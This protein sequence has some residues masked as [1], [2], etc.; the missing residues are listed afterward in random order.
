MIRARGNGYTIVETMIFLVVSGALL[1]SV[2]VLVDGQQRK[3]EFSTVVRDFDS[4]LQSMIGNVSTG[5]YNNTGQTTCITAG[6]PPP[7]SITSITT[8][9]TRQGQNANCTFI[10][11]VMIPL[12]PVNEV[13]TVSIYST[14]GLRLNS[15]SQEVQNLSQARPKLITATSDDFDLP[16]GMTVSMKVSGT[17]FRSLGVF[18]TFN[19][20]SSGPVST[21]SS[22][23]SRSNIY[24]LSSPN[25]A[26]VEGQLLSGPSP[27]SS[28][29]QICLIDGDQVGV[30]MLNTGST[31]VTIGNTCP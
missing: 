14:A 8:G 20:Y 30:I 26:G 22:G 28:S 1:S 15:S 7:T 21:L 10:G 24:A 12:D 6:G 16:S 5:Y 11:Q 2:M 18:T 29:I 9:G 13:T 4:K 31:T 17:P 23:S 25:P 3:T 19:Q 27:A